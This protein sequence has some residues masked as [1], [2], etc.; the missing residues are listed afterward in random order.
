[1]MKLISTAALLVVF[2]GLSAEAQEYSFG[3]AVTQ[4]VAGVVALVPSSPSVSLSHPALMGFANSKTSAEISY[5]QLFGLSELEDLT[6]HARHKYR[7]F[8]GGMSVAR[9]GKAGLYQEYTLS[10]ASSFQVRQDLAVGAALQ[11]TSTEFGD[12]QSR[13]AGAE[14]ALSA[15][16]RPV[17]SLLVSVGTRRL[18]LDRTYNDIETDPVYEASIAWTSVSE[19]SLGAI[20]TRERQGDHRF[21]LGQVLN[22]TRSIDF[23]A[24][25][26]FNP[27]RYTLGGRALHGGIALI[28]AFEGHPDLGSTHSFGVSW[29]R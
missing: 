19:V 8:N 4:G 23:L 24:G 25:L 26:R 6:V 12:A 22:L 16:Y 28:Y 17:T 18:T 7:R 21:A 13:Y 1:M 10:G 2:C 3:S 20:W 27:V 11:Y 9:F 5:R 15:A 29:S 14:L